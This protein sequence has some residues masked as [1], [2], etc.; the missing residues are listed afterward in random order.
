VF[1]KAVAFMAQGARGL[2]YGRNIYQ[3]PDMGRVTQA[4]LAII[5]DGAGSSEAWDIY[6]RSTA[7]AIAG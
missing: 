2:V 4:L 7:G 1:D 3:H 6:S 5:H